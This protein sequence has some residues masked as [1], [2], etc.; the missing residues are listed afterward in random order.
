MERR[1]QSRPRRL[2]RAGGCDFAVD[3]TLRSDQTQVVWLPRHNPRMVLLTTGTH[4][5]FD[6]PS[7]ES[8]QPENTLAAPEGLYVDLVSV[9]PAH[10]ALIN[11]PVTPGS[12]IA[13]VIPLDAHFE[14]RIEAAG[15]L[16][17]VLVRGSQARPT[18]FGAQRRRQ[19]KQALRALDG[20]LDGAGYREIARG[21]FRDRVP[22]EA[23]WRSHSLRSAIIRL[24]RDGRALMQDRY[25]GLLRPERRT[26]RRGPGS[27]AS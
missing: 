9:S 23:S 5:L 21:L 20:A 6:G 1:R 3:P 15:R 8:A 22:D 7:L 26:R 12:T 10:Q 11:G 25:L 4:D 19:L 27:S 17:R 18:G 13:L 16:W 24:V 2:R 14:H